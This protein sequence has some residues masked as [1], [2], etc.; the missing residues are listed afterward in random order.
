MNLIIKISLFVSSTLLM[1]YPLW[2]LLFPESFAVELTQ[3]HA[4]SE[5][6]S[7]SQVRFSAAWLWVPNTVLAIALLLQFK[8]LGSPRNT[9]LGVTSGICF[10]L[11]PFTRIFSEVMVEKTMLAKSIGIEISSEKLFFVIIGLMVIGLTNLISNSNG[12]D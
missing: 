6:Y 11:Y 5:G 12:N 7:M 2:G 9:R 8:L 1:V 10:I 4:F 3:H